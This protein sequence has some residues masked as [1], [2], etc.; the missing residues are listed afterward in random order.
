MVFFD[1]IFMNLLT[2]NS[3]HLFNN[4]FLKML[5][6]KCF[7]FSI[8]LW[9]SFGTSQDVNG[10]TSL[11]NNQA[12]ILTSSNDINHKALIVDTHNENN[13]AN[14]SYKTFKTPFIPSNNKVQQ[15][16]AET[17]NYKL[18]Y[19]DIGEIIPLKLTSRTLIFPFHFFT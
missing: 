18:L 2:P 19:I 12:E 3:L 14:W 16:N 4:I 1:K 7:I 9:L 11:F 15:P 17:Y 5:H 10:V 8:F 13:Q 6:F